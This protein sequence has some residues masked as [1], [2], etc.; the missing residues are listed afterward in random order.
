MTIK[1]VVEI[2][3]ETVEVKTLPETLRICLAD[4][5]NKDA[6]EQIH[7]YEDTEEKRGKNVEEIIRRG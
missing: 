3:G 7:F 6:L 1:N 4:S 5:L 2:D